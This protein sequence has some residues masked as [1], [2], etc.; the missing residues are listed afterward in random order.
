MLT[1]RKN[2]PGKVSTVHKKITLKLLCF[3]LAVPL[4]TGLFINGAFAME[5]H[6]GSIGNINMNEHGG[7][8]SQNH[9]YDM[10]GMKGMNMPG[11]DSHG[12]MTGSGSHSVSGGEATGSA[13]GTQPDW[14]FIYTMGAIN[15]LVIVI[16]AL[17][18]KSALKGNGV[19]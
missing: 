18:K 2:C 12:G 16:A 15:L 6:P 13:T 3:L 11:T 4:I 17:M 19:N 9:D 8:H 10:G 1:I 7:D 14:P 5:N